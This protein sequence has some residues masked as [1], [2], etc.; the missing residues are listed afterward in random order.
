MVLSSEAEDLEWETGAETAVFDESDYHVRYW[1]I[2]GWWQVEL[3]GCI[4]QKGLAIVIC[5][6]VIVKI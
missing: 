5:S 3:C 1:R 6:S 2:H 4:E